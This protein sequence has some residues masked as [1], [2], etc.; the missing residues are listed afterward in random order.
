MD[1]LTDAQTI[2][3]REQIAFLG[4]A[5]DRAKI[6]AWFNACLNS[7]CGPVGHRYGHTAV[8]VLLAT[9]AETARVKA[10]AA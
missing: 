8:A 1:P 9:W 4:E 6:S 2:L 3:D 5:P 10:E 7:A